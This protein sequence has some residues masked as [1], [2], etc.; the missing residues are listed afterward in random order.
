MTTNSPHERG[1]RKG[2]RMRAARRSLSAFG[3][4]VFT[5]GATAA[6][7]AELPPG[8]N[9]DLVARECQACHDFDMVLTLSGDR[10]FWDDLIDEMTSYGLRVSPDER[11][12]ILDYLTTTLAPK[13][14]Q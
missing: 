5:L 12:K 6:R 13:P 9:R 3:F 11:A 1:R 10:A 8:P 2:G 14:A 4:A 7:A